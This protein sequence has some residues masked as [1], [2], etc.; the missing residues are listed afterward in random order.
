MIGFILIYIGTMLIAH[1]GKNTYRIKPC[2]DE[3]GAHYE[4]KKSY[5]WFPFK[6]FDLEFITVY[7]SVWEAE[8]AIERD[9]MGMC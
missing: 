6:E 1:K 5:W 7:M 3:Y 9:K 8:R 2:I 4:V